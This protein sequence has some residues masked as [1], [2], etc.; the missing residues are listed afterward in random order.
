MRM[1]RFCAPGTVIS[2]CFGFLP[3]WRRFLP[4]RPCGLPVGPIE[5]RP[6]IS[7]RL[8]ACCSRCAACSATIRRRA[9]SER[10]VALG[11]FAF[12]RR[13]TPGGK[14]SWE[15]RPCSPG[16]SGS[17]CSESGWAARCSCGGTGAA[18][19]TGVDSAA[20]GVS[21]LGGSASVAASAALV[22]RAL[23]AIG[24]GKGSWAG[25]VSGASAAAGSAFSVFLRRFRRTTVGRIR[26][27]T[28]ASLRSLPSDR[29]MRSTSTGS[30]T[31][32]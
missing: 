5:E 25:L 2:V 12:P 22:G 32:M 3:G 6:R 1:T 4:G 27:S 29:L 10:G 28:M 24:S 26:S 14:G 23:G 8:G 20:T 19:G 9:P 15:K 30:R 13:M 7:R 18:G 31:L 17:S 16:A 11:A 21:S